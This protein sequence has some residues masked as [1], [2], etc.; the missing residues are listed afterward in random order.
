MK[1]DDDFHAYW[2]DFWWFVQTLISKFKLVCNV[3]LNLECTSL[4]CCK[5][6]YFDDSSMILDLN[7]SLKQNLDFYSK[8]C[9]SRPIVN[10]SLFTPKILFFCTEFEKTQ[11]TKVWALWVGFPLTPESPWY[12]FSIG[13]YDQNT[14]L[15]PVWEFNTLFEI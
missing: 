12:H 2:S 3:A 7:W 6:C 5:S 10:C 8:F 11:N 9:F 1:I 4:Y 14:K 15:C 13:S